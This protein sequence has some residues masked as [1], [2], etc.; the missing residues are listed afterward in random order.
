MEARASVRYRFGTSAVFSWK[1]QAGSWLKGEGVTR[2]ICIGGA[3]IL[4]PTC[5]PPEAVIQ[6]EIILTP[7]PGTNGRQLK[8]VTEGRVLR[9]EHPAKN[10]ARDGFAVEGEGFEILDVGADPN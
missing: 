6:L 8:I 5:P 2:D 10:K 3:Y 1:S 9:V 4:T 7:S